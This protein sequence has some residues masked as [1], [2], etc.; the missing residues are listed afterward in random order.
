M[1]GVRVAV[2]GLEPIV[3]KV[4][5]R[6]RDDCTGT[7]RQMAPLPLLLLVLGSPASHNNSGGRTLALA[8][9]LAGTAGNSWDVEELEGGTAAVVDP[10]AAGGADEMPGCNAHWDSCNSS[11][12]RRWRLSLRDEH[13]APTRK[14]RR[15][16]R[17]RRT[18]VG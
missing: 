10:G 18:G 12:Q 6:R 5:G 11:R 8:L 7:G 15:R 14:A 16:T 4:L 17:T 13:L 3:E 9:A 1:P 2:V